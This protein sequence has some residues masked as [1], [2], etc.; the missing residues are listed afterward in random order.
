MV[1]SYMRHGPTQAFGIVTSPTANSTYNGRLAFVPG[2]EDVLVWDVKLGQLVSMWHSPGLTSQVTHIKPAPTPYTS[3]SQGSQTFAVSY[4]DGSIRLWTY[5]SE[6]PEAEAE[7]AVTFNG[8]K[9]SVTSMTWDSD[10]SRLASGGTEGE[11]VVW[12][13]VGEVGLFRLK[14]HRAPITGLAF[15]PHPKGSHAGFLIS[16]SK[17]TYMKVWDL[18]TQHCVQTVVVGRGEV[19][20]LALREEDDSPVIAQAE[21][22]NGDGVEEDHVGGRWTVTTGT[23]DGESKVYSLSKAAL[24][25]GLQPLADGSLP[26]LLVSLCSLPVSSSTH[27][28]SQISWHP[29]LPLLALQTTDR[30]VVIMR[31]RTEE[32]ISAKRSRRK[33]RDREKKKKAKGKDEKED[34]VEEED[35]EPVK[36]EERVAVW[37]VVRANA[38]VK[39]FAFASES[40]TFVKGG[41]SLLLALSNNSIESY[42][43][44]SPSASGKSKLADGS[45]PEPTKTHSIELPGHRQ[46]I[47]TVSI[48][49]DDGVIASASSGT[50]KI[51]NAR[52]TACIRTMECGYALCSTFLPGDRHVVVGTK[53]GELMLY[54]VGASTL[55]KTYKAHNGPVW[56]IGVRPDGRGLVS[57]SADKDVKFWDFE[58][59]EEGEGERVVSRLGVETVYKTKQ[60][61]LVHVRT[62]K[63][64]DDILALKYTPNGRFL[65]VSLLDSTVKMFF[66]DTLKFFLSLYGHKLPVLSLDISTDSKLIVTCSADKNVKIW[67][68]D[69]GDC[70]KSIFAH[71]EAIMG[72]M[73]EKEAG[74]HNFWTVSKDRIIKYWDGDKFELIQKLSGHHG[75][76]WALATASNGQ[77]VVTGS[78]DKSIRIWE[79]TDEPLFLDEE[80]EKEIEDMYDSNLADS[81][82]RDPEGQNGEGEGGEVEAVQKQTA[83]TLIAGEKIMEAITVADEDRLAVQ[84]W[85]ED[86]EKAGAEVPR[87]PRHAELIAR[88]DLEP[89]QYVLQTVKK[90]PAASME[91]ALLV[92]PF[93]MVVSL[94]G[95]LDEWA[96]QGKEVILVSRILFFLLRT[97]SAQIV[98]NR[99]MRTP[100]LTL[101]THLRQALSAQRDTMGF[102]IAALK[103]LKGRWEGERVAGMYEE[104][105]MDEE[106]VRKRLE[107]G[108]G[109]RKRVEVRA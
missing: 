29:T 78:H 34:E 60:L 39:S 52:T 40:S 89:D 67:G 96:M 53:G 28:I 79:K 85:E 75:E 94:M 66:S 83:E 13:R 101:R 7:E 46:D 38:K 36:W 31:L 55:L 17:D 90:I 72:V 9:K 19:T 92:L 95:Y 87:P 106:A 104:E 69:F 102:N 42:N 6:S 33:K 63:M 37:C 51:W 49:S 30:G 23:S 59:R 11:I 48:S 74:S 77:F 57:G 27:P 4:Q 12:D 5:D 44:P 86:C 68:M 20:A 65:A 35:D 58:M 22:E 61:A 71:D 108:R 100:L 47:R 97:H 16:T 76:V 103:F 8:H 56:S 32:E 80:R 81:L 105:G 73:F 107:D 99:I 98:S 88:G 1:R 109:K 25:T 26:S 15:V 45:S 21:E 54:D 93:R 64:T 50:L 70:H 24:A 3:T 91:D 82:N 43:I 62:L 41:V 84:Q 2:W 18:S 14:G 10:A